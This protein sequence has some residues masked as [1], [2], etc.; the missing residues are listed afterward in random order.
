MGVF[1]DEIWS[2]SNSAS[3]GTGELSHNPENACDVTK[4]ATD[5]EGSSSL[6]CCT[7]SLMLG[8]AFETVCIVEETGRSSVASPYVIIDVACDWSA[9]TNKKR[10]TDDSSGVSCDHLCSLNSEC[11]IPE[12][13][14]S[15]GANDSDDDVC[16][17][18]WSTCGTFVKT[19]ST[20]PNERFGVFHCWLLREWTE[21][22]VDTTHK[23]GHVSFTCMLW[24]EDTTV[25]RG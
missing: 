21:V 13:A 25:V 5:G 15:D 1:K 18:T 19:N 20:L 17:S 16:W 22:P 7:I 12:H 9:L 6:C 2:A 14:T 10:N 24:G 11:T 23:V 8:A 3:T 4:A